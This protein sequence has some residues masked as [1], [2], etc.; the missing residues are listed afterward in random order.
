MTYKLLTLT[1]LSLVVISVGSAGSQEPLERAQSITLETIAQW[2]S[3]L[4]NWGRWGQNDQ[5]GALN[6]ITQAKRRQAATLVKAG[7]SVSLAR[8]ADYTSN[9]DTEINIPGTGPYI[10][11]MARPTLDWFALRYHGWAHTHIDSLA[12][13]TDDGQSY[14]GYIADTDKVLI[15]GHA[16]N[17]ITVAEEGIFTRGILMDI[18][19]LKGVSYLEPGT[20]IFPSDLEAWEQQAGITVSS[21]DAL[22]IRTGRWTRRAEL[23]PWDARSHSAG[24]D[25]SVIPW[26][27][28]RDIAI[29]AGESPQ[30]AVPPGGELTGLPVH[31]FALVYL[32]VHLF[33]NVALDDIAEVAATQNRWEFLLTVAPL[34]MSG[35]TGSPINPIATF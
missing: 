21:G 15:D 3:E 25:A 17:A 8:R 34:R 11:H 23:G 27:R 7:V 31:N 1:V 12:H 24:L 19:R 9:P 20:R 18:P 22:F 32:G 14:N 4:S 29:L 30:D 33:D 35:G 2:K 13:G 26:L 16:T 5:Q 28:D 10:R 6:L